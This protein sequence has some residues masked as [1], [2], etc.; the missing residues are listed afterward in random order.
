MT[1]TQSTTWIHQDREVNSLLHIWDSLWVT[2]GD[3]IT[4]SWNWSK[5]EIIK[6]SGPRALK[7]G[8]TSVQIE[9]PG[10]PNFNNY[11]IITDVIPM[12]LSEIIF[13]IIGIGRAEIFWLTFPV[14]INKFETLLGCCVERTVDTWNIMEPDLI[15]M[16]LQFYW[17]LTLY[18]LSRPCEN[19]TLD[20]YYWYLWSTVF[21][22]IPV[23]TYRELASF[24]T[25][26]V[27]TGW[28][29]LHLLPLLTLW[30]CLQAVYHHPHHPHKVLLQQEIQVVEKN[31]A[32]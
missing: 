28:Q 17:S 18:E 10:L 24:L 26:L 3:K 22:R 14:D 15:L 31:T 9:Q 19:S 30:R 7:W 6:S 13:D 29:C 32:Q 11:S 1:I 27:W 8:I 25:L 2:N 16:C 20:C 4:S 5:T 23:Q 21:Y 12:L